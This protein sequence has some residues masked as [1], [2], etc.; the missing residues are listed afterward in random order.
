MKLLSRSFFFRQIRFDCF[1]HH[2][3]DDF[4]PATAVFGKPYC[5]IVMF[6]HC[7]TL[8]ICTVSVASRVCLHS[9]HPSTTVLLIWQPLSL[10]MFQRTIVY[11]WEHVQVTCVLVQVIV[12]CYRQFFFPPSFIL[13]H[14]VHQGILCTECTILYIII[15][16]IVGIRRV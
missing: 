4:L 16:L 1:H 11:V 13:R 15:M 5:D 9:T 10:Q 3:T 8:S 12:E 7:V 14:C 2:L 6:V